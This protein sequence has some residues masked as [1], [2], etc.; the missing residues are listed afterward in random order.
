ML[1]KIWSW[2]WVI[3]GYSYFV[4]IWTVGCYYVMDWVADRIIDAWDWCEAK[5]INW[6]TRKSL[7]EGVEEE[8]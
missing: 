4:A 1:K 5:Y 7:K 8:L 6:K 3:V 2:F